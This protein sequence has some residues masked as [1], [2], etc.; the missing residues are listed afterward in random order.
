[1]R[2]PFVELKRIAVADFETDAIATRPKYPPVP[3]GLALLV[4]GQRPFYHAWGHP[5]NNNSSKS[6]AIKHYKDLQ[7]QGYVFVW[8]HAGFDLDV[9]ETHCGVPWPAEHHDTLLL[10]FLND[11]RAKTFSLKPSAERLLGEAPAERDALKEWIVK[12]VPGAKPKTWGAFIAKAPGDLVGKYACGDVTRTWGLFKLFVKTVL[13]DLPQRGAY[14]RERR[15]TRVLIRM[16]RRGVPVATKRLKRD[17]PK[18]E[19]RLAA[20]EGQLM[21]RLKVPKTKREDFTWSGERFADQLE[22]CKAVKEWILTEKGARS[23]GIDSL[24]EVGVEPTLV[25]ELETRAQVQTCLSTFMRPWLAQGLAY[26][27]RFYARFNQVRQDYHGAEGRLVGT[28]T[29]RLSMT[30]NLQN[31]TRSDKDERVP[32]VRDYIV[33]GLILNGRTY[34]DLALNR[35]D[36]SQQELR[37][38]AHYENGPFLAKYLANPK[39]DAH[40]AVRDLINELIGLLLE[41]RFIKDLNFGLIYGMGMAKLALKL[42]MTIGETRK[43]FRALLKAMPG[44]EKLKKELSA[45]ED[46]GEC[47]YTW[48]GRKYYCEPAKYVESRGRTMKFGYKLLNLKVQGSAADCTKQAMVNYY[49]AGYDDKWPLLLQVHDELITLSHIKDSKKAHLGLRECMADVDFKVPMLSEGKT[50]TVSW[51]QMSKVEW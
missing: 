27:D 5:S 9:M 10:N 49:E 12:H 47:L 24:K 3:V 22:R 46:S 13:S 6:D 36:Y 23:T 40:N 50:G 25:H 11:P 14:D 35:R 44:V 21:D 51:H 18:Y 38:L 32:V 41:R 39:I 45:L 33:P 1:M 8:H 26:D 16:E 28:E 43:L 31:V 17:V 7:R 4:P 34:K 30:P 20:L 2:R 37:I 42:G 48:G 19:T 15:L 29:G